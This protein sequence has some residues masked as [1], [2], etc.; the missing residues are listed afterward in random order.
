MFKT[1]SNYLYF[2]VLLISFLIFLCGIFCKISAT[3][4]D[5]ETPQE[6]PTQ[7]NFLDLYGP[8]LGQEIPG[9]EPVAFADGIVNRK[10]LHSTPSVSPDGTEIYWSEHEIDSPQGCIYFSKRVNNRWTVPEILIP[11]SN[12][13]DDGPVFST[14]GQT[15]Y[16]NSNRPW[17]GNTG[18][19]HERIWYMTRQADSSWSSPL[20]V[21]RVIS[22]YALHW[23]VSVD[24]NGTLYFGSE[25]TPNYG[26][27]DIFCSENNNG[28][29]DFPVNL[30]PPVN[31]SEHESM[32]FIDPE[33][34][35]LL[36]GRPAQVNGTLTNC[37]WI[38]R[39]QTNGTWSVPANVTA[40]YPNFEGAC[41]KVT[42]DGKYIFHLR[43]ISG[44]FYVY[45]ISSEIL[46]EF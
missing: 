17:P 42:P 39:K 46:D 27:D 34:R 10:S 25:R 22:D 23:Q 37:I 21:D 7:E 26:L 30:G 11:S 3:S 35:Y 12:Y 36:F 4:T 8:Y 29:F 5:N 16:F 45:W 38:S 15:L 18:T 24:N 41:A 1:K 14:D 43:Y 6:N 31:T 40:T 20:P 33:G 13:L 2:I 44:N 32:P 19:E 9:T 28:H